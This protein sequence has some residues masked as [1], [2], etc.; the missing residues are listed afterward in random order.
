MTALDTFWEVIDAQIE[1]LKTA[2]TADEVI[3]ILANDKNPYGDPDIGSG[4]GFFA[5]SGGDPTVWGAL[6]EAGWRTVWFEADYHFAMASPNQP[7]TYITYVEGDI[8]K[9]LHTAPR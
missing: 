8:Y 9:D 1:Q 6:A 7:T 2:K 4:D 3:D 5:G